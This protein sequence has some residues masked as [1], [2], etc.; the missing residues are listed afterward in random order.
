[1]RNQRLVRQLLLLKRIEA[2]T[3]IINGVWQQFFGSFRVVEMSPKLFYHKYS[4]HFRGHK[5]HALATKCAVEECSMQL[6]RFASF[7]KYGIHC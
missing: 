3:V 1:M 4:L 2:T 5:F 7:F 6:A